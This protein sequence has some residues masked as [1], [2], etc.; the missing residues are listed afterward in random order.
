MRSVRQLPIEVNPPE[1]I[2]YRAI[3]EPFFTQFKDEEHVAKINELIAD[4]LKLALEQPEI[5]LVRGFAL[6]LQSRSLALLMKTPIE[7]AEEWLSWGLHVFFPGPDGKHKGQELED[8]IHR[9]LDEAVTSP[10]KDMFSALV[11]A[12][13]QGRPLTREEMVGFANLAFAGGRD[14]MINSIVFAFA[15]LARDPQAIGW[16][17][18]DPKR[19]ILASEELFR[20]LSPV[21]LLGRICPHGAN[22]HGVDVAP[23]GRVAFGWAAANFDE[24]VF[25]EP[26]E[27]RL[28]RK[29]NPH[30]AFGYGPHTCLGAP[31]ARLVIRSLLLQIAEKIQ[32]IA[33]LEEE[34]N[35]ERRDD[36]ERFAG[37]HMLRVRL[38]PR[39]QR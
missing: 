20:A 25:E 1:H 38:E 22:I 12:Q 10:G 4:H 26:E 29:P 13:F 15:H 2:E 24:T 17:R 34:I 8:Y 35:Y 27:V 9:K 39:T 14:T 30:I 21:S 7:E 36:I 19:I 3:V 33:I 16:L 31:H 23:N 11:H 28:D 32:T 18:E 5:E 6:P 37:Y